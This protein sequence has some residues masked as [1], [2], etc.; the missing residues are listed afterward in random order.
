MEDLSGLE[1]NNNDWIDKNNLSESFRNI[2]YEIGSTYIPVLKANYE[3]TYNKQKEVNVELN[4]GLWTQKPFPYQAKCLKWLREEYEILED[5]D[6]KFVK[7]F[8]NE[9]GCELLFDGK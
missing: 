9:T 5:E 7:N 8:L 4:Y 3:A 1:I 2:F 6:K